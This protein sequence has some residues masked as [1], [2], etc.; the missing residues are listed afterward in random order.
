MSKEFVHLHLHTEYSLLDGA[1]KI[2]PLMKLIKDYGMNAVAITDHGNLFGAIEFYKTAKEFNI[3][4]IIGIEAYLTPGDRREKTKEKLYHI[5]LLAENDEGYKNLLYLTTMSFLEGFY[6]KP[7]IDKEL[8]REHSGGLIALSGCLSGEIP[9]KILANDE[10]GARKALNEYIEIFGKENFFL[11]LMDIGLDENLIVNQKLV[12]LSKEYGVGIVATNDV[13]Y[14]EPDDYRAHDILLCIQ[15]GKKVHDPNRMRFKSREV[16]L[17]RPDE[18]WALFSSTPEA[19]EN[20]LKIAERINLELKLDPTKVHLPSFPIPDGFDSTDE[21]L[22]YVAR[23]GLE[24]RGKAGIETYENRLEYELKTISSI[25]FSGYFLIVWDIVKKA[26]GMG[27]PVGPGRGSAS[28]S[29]VLYSLGVTELDPIEYNLLFERFLNTERISP[30]DVDIDFSDVGRDRIISYV[31]ELYGEESVS[32]IITFNRMMAKGIIRDVGRALDLSYQ[33]VDRIAKMIPN[34]TDVTIEKVVKS[35]P[36]LKDIFDSDPRYREL[37]EISTRIEGQV[38]NTSIHAAGMVIAPGKI[39]EYA[40]LYKSP[41]GSITTQYDMKSI[42]EIG[43][44]KVDFLGLRTLT[45]IQWTE[46][47]IRERH[48]PNFDITKIPLDDQKTYKMIS[49][50]KTLGVFQLESSGFRE[51]LRRLKP[52]KIEDLIA[53][54][55]L[56]RPGPLKSGMVES[57]IKRKNGKEPVE[58]DFPELKPILEETYGVIVYQEQVMQ[59]A[60]KLAGFTLGQADVLRKAMGKK[61]P[62]VMKKQR[63]AFIKGAVKN[64]HDRK[65]VEKLFDDI[66]KFAGYGFNK[67][68]AAGYGLLSYR[69]AYLKAHYPNEFLCANMTAETHSQNFTEKIHQFVNEAKKWGIKVVP[70]E[71]NRS[72]YRFTLLEDGSILFGLSAIKNVGEAAVEEIVRARKKGGPFKSFKNF[73]ERIDSRKVNKKV[74]ESLIKA[75]AFDNLDPNRAKL[76]EILPDLYSRTQKATSGFVGSLFGENYDEQTIVPDREVE[77]NLDLKLSYEKE[78]LGFFLSGHPLN[79]HKNLINKLKIVKSSK[80]RELK[81]GKR[82]SLVGYLVSV[83]SKKSN[84]GE[85]YA[86]LVFEDFDGEFNAIAFPNLYKEIAADLMKDTIYIITGKLTFDDDENTMP[87]IA[88]ES[89]KQLHEG[90]YDM[91]KSVV[92]TVKDEDKLQDD[93]IERLY[94]VISVNSGKADLY[95]VVT[96]K[97]LR[98]KSIKVNPTEDLIQGIERILGKNTVTIHI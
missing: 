49:Q 34:G 54:I 55:A 20:T 89:I 44:L 92:V 19:L 94:R 31:R 40:P 17:R 73:L 21:Y 39:Y 46:E 97:M 81:E 88:I 28:G 90:I 61:K 5:T 26:K 66:E 50:G 35:N 91:T 86:N 2:K 83:K 80:L 7:R 56:Y 6:Y 8:L 42:E 29:L 75:G 71:I 98:S 12:E 37:Y 87:R 82:V 93:V 96:G 63:E 30:P 27:I 70:P 41:D 69:T 59:I 48:D 36:E 68:H 95:F 64:G 11:E 62:E 32:Q 14:L 79:K 15:T 84:R 53:A 22:A 77:F 10:E 60:A 85:P 1:C 52:S 72:E 25:G 76:L 24:A 13:H 43:L 38:K 65:K 45:I 78:T 67:S 9:R 74:I 23:K 4:P 58:Y 33:E 57:F 47:M 51:M 3:K 18:M 16:Y